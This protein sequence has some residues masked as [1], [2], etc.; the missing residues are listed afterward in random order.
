MQA[1]KS[2]GQNFLNNQETLASIISAADLNKNDQVIEIGPGHG[3]LT[4]ELVKNAG[5]VTAIELDADLIPELKCKF[6]QDQNFKLINQNALEFTPPKTP[7][8]LVANIPYYIT[9]P[10]INHF[11]REQR[12]ESRPT[13]IVLLVQK[14]VA[15]KI[16]AKDGSLSVLAIQV[17]LFGHPEIIATVP[18]SHFTPAPKVDSAIIKITVDKQI[19][20]P[21]EIK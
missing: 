14:E 3:V 15:E 16:C 13:L 19:I 10:I 6:L 17:H 9:S 8:K 5:S 2:L 21:E 4:E 18:A 12:P 7:Y 20:E 11:L 1:K